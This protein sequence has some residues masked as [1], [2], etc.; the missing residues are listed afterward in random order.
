MPAA[1]HVRPGPCPRQAGGRTDRPFPGAPRQVEVDAATVDEMLDR[2]DELW[3]G[4]RDRLA[5]SSPAVR[6]HINIFL[7]GERTKLDTPSRPAP[8]S[9]YSRRS[10]ADEQQAASWSDPEIGHRLSKIMLEIEMRFR[11]SR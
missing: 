9:S 11:E 10:A 3:P 8:R 7:A 6:R 5:D 2:L 1:A 4:M